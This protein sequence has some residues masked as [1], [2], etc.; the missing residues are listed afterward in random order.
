MLLKL[1]LHRHNTEICQV[2]TKPKTKYNASTVN[3][4]ATWN[5]G[6]GGVGG[7]ENQII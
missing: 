3:V 1:E 4:D 6:S 2:T 5:L 7:R